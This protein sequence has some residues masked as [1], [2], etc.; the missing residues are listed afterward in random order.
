MTYLKDRQQMS[1]MAMHGVFDDIWKGIEGIWKRPG[2][3]SG[4]SDA[5]APL[6]EFKVT[7]E[8]STS[9]LPTVAYEGGVTLVSDKTGKPIT[10][11]EVVGDYVK[12]KGITFA[13]NG[14]ALERL[15]GLQRAAN[16]V[17]AAKGFTAVVPDG[18]IGPASLSLLKQIMGT[19]ASFPSPSPQ[20]VQN[21]AAYSMADSLSVAKRSAELT[22]L[23]G[24]VADAYS[25][26]AVVPTPPPSSPPVIVQPGPTLDSPM[27]LKSQGTGASISDVFARMGTVQKL[28]LA[29]AVAGLGVYVYKTR[30]K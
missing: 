20:Y 13:T 17:A 19:L 7:E 23:I 22:D 18:K 28:L 5:V 11:R 10:S 8:T 25:A 24:Q 14:A 6:P 21:L 27:Q 30:S 26:P 3:S 29:G 2:D 15:K 12:V 16:R 1:G 9:A 4:G